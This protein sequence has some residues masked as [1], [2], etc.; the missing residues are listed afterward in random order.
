MKLGART[1]TSALSLTGLVMLVML[2]IS[3]DVTA[4]GERAQQANVRMRTINW[5]DVEISPAKVE[6]GDIVTIK[7][8]MRVSKFWPDHLPSVT[9]RVFLNVGTSGPNFV[10]LA[11]HIDGV[12]MIQSTS[13]DLGRDYSFDMSLTAR[14]PGRFHVHPVLSV[15]DAGGMV[16]PGVW[17]DVYGDP[18]SF[19]TP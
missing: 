2:G 10:R 8:R 15:L 5:Y 1:L 18:D 19:R 6:I 13:L 14:R 12:S 11:S 7:G 4:H 16:G 17:I 3:N 9:E